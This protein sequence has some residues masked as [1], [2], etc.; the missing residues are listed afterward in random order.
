MP[1]F[2]EVALCGLGLVMLSPLLLLTALLVKLTSPGP[3]FFRQYRAGHHGRPFQLLK[4]RS[5]IHQ[6]V[7]DGA[8]LTVGGDRRVTRLGGLLRRTKLDEL[9]QLWNV[10]RGD[11]ALVGPRPE[12][13]RYVRCHPQLFELALSRKP[14]ITDLC[15]LRLRQE[16]HLLAEIED[17]ERYYIETLLPRK[18]AASIRESW[19]RTF[20]RDMRVLIATVVPPLAFLAPAAD[21]RPLAELFTLPGTAP[22]M[23]AAAPGRPATPTEQHGRPGRHAADRVLAGSDRRV[24]IGA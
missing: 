5:M 7:A 24:E 19:K 17:P 9:P 20:W 18:L 21:F 16:E 10:I 11:M 6:P 2:M 8:L 12:V 14:G 23:A 4:F 13:L 22:L 1:R 3:V 15:T